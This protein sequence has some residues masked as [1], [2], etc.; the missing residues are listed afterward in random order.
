MGT[1]M[2]PR[3]PS[4]SSG[5]VTRI[6]RAGSARPAQL[7]EAS[8]STAAKGWPRQARL[9]TDIAEPGS[10]E[11]HAQLRGEP[12][13]EGDPA[14]PLVVVVLREVDVG[15]PRVLDGSS[16]VA[17]VPKAVATVSAMQKVFSALMIFLFGLALRNM[18]KVK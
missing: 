15:P 4:S 11:S 12:P 1:D 9:G 16:P 5:R 6:A 10:V 7:T 13:D 18:L 14:W 8:A 17:V 2:L 3:I